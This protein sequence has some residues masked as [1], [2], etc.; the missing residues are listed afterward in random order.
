MSYKS[1][2]EI[3]KM[4]E[5]IQ[6]IVWGKFGYYIKGVSPEDILKM[7]DELK[8]LRQLMVAVWPYVHLP[9][10][11]IKAPK[12]F[13]DCVKSINKIVMDEKEM[14]KEN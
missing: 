7:L 11:T 1:K 9:S 3:E 12:A 10:G 2:E 6:K 13:R 14:L 4:H 8:R 5:E